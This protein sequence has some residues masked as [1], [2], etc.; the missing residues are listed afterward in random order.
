MADVPSV[1]DEDTLRERHHWQRVARRYQRYLARN[2]WSAEN[3]VRYG[4][5]LQESGELNSAA[6]AYAVAL[7]LGA[8]TS[9][10][11]HL[12]AG[13]LQ[14]V[15]GDTQKAMQA[16]KSALKLNPENLDAADGLRD[17]GI[18]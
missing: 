12:Q 14:E 9:S 6:H 4:F 10:D 7:S 17:L 8:D 1:A 3:W 2:I 15:Q 16:Y 13:C 11:A 5:A 18:S